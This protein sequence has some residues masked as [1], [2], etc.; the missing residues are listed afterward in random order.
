M[1]MFC[2]LHRHLPL[3]NHFNLRHLIQ[4]WTIAA[5]NNSTNWHSEYGN[6]CMQLLCVILI[7]SIESRIKDG[8]NQCRIQSNNISWWVGFCRVL[9]TNIHA[10][11]IIYRLFAIL[12]FFSPFNLIRTFIFQFLL[13]A[14][15]ISLS[16]FLHCNIHFHLLLM[17]IVKWSSVACVILGAS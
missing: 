6:I 9:F 13:L 15:A 3:E 17:P 8:L 14:S 11:H 7:I 2:W 5:I 10:C 1:E 12:S 4:N 16:L